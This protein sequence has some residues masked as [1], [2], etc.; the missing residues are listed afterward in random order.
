LNLLVYY[1]CRST[2]DRVPTLPLRRHNHHPEN[3]I[4][5]WAQQARALTGIHAPRKEV[6][7]DPGP[8]NAGGNQAKD[9]PRF[10]PVSSSSSC[11]VSDAGEGCEAIIGTSPSAVA[12]PT[13]FSHFR[14]PRA[15]QSCNMCT[16][17]GNGTQ[18]RAVQDLLCLDDLYLVYLI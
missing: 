12:D 1:H 3:V 15:I 17:S 5:N 2:A 10:L 6:R 16:C 9:S 18:E 7:P 14:I 4:A 13:E 11:D 8:A